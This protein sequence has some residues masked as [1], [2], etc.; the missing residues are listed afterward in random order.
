LTSSSA[1]I[2]TC[3][4]HYSQVYNYRIHYVS[5]CILLKLS[6]MVGDSVSC[7][8][9]ICLGTPYHF[10]K[11]RVI[12]AIKILLIFQDWLAL[13]ACW[14]RSKYF[15]KINFERNI[16]LFWNNKETNKK[17]CFGKK[18]RCDPKTKCKIAKFQY[19]W[20][21]IAILRLAF[22]TIYVFCQAFLITCHSKDV[23]GI[24]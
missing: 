16:S 4:N 1:V 11:H 5:L 19:N 7:E 17:T 3:K 23:R 20:Q 13:I 2:W 24:I 10:N 6:Y 18:M 14:V 21:F 22:L 15:S 8:L 9:K 12:F